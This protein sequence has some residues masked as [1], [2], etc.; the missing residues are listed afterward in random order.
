MSARLVKTVAGVES[1]WRCGRQ[2]TKAGTIVPVDDLT[3]DEWKRIME[4]PRL[5]VEPASEAD[6]VENGDD[7]ALRRVIAEAI[8]QL[9]AED[10]Q[11]DGKPRI[12]A[13]KE[14]LPEGTKINAALRDEVFKE[15]VEGGFTAPAEE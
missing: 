7:E 8:H 5:V 10:F 15:E 4:E 1:F 12:E 11:K 3:D 6:L 13:L 14:L 2:W 9:G